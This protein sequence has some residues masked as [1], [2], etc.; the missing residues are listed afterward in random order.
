LFACDPQAN[1]HRIVFAKGEFIAPYLGEP[2]TQSG[3]AK[4]YFDAVADPSVEYIRTP[5]G[6]GNGRVHFDGAILR[7]PAVYCN[8]AKGTRHRNTAC[9]RANPRGAPCLY[10]TADIV[11][12]E[13]I[14]TG[15]GTVYWASYALTFETVLL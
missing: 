13:E 2:L 12:G 15:Y 4:R 14:F 10:A 1:D 11:N 9:I 7:G 6:T 8:D 3:L 5:Y